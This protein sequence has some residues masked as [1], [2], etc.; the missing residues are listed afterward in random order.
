MNTDCVICSTPLVDDE[1]DCEKCGL[2][3]HIY[4]M[5]PSSSDTCLACAAMNSP[6]LNA[7]QVFAFNTEQY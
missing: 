5:C 7:T 4:S 2:L 3:C 1:V 6:N